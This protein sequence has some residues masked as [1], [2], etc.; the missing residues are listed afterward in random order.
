M[1]VQ[2]FTEDVQ[3]LRS[4]TGKDE[5]LENLSVLSSRAFSVTFF[6]PFLCVLNHS[7]G[8]PGSEI[9]RQHCSHLLLPSSRECAGFALKYSASRTCLK[10][11]SRSFRNGD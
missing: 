5:G 1:D 10:G 6:A 9:I 11:A 3:S 7:H 8:C 2:Q 4:L